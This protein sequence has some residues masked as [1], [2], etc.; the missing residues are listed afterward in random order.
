M[1]L[2]AKFGVSVTTDCCFRLSN[3]AAQCITAGGIEEY[4]TI[5]KQICSDTVHIPDA[6]SPSGNTA[7]L[8]K[9]YIGIMF[10]TVGEVVLTRL[11][12]VSIHLVIA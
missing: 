10:N 3:R 12:V 7:L 6:K 1:C 4:C 2:D 11:S 8:P 9:E 5:A